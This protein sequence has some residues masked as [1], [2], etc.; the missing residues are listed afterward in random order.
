[1]TFDERHQ[2]LPLPPHAALLTSGQLGFSIDLC[3]G[4]RCLCH[5]IRIASYFVTWP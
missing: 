2:R 3:A 5:K 4:L 1:M